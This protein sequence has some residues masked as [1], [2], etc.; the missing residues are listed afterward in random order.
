MNT[1]QYYH[2]L[3]KP[4]FAPPS[5]IFGIVWPFLYLL[6]A[7]SFGYVFYQVLVKKQWSKK[8]LVPFTLN[9]IS[10]ALY[11]PLF[12]TWRLLIPATIDILIVLSTIIWVIVLMNNKK[13]WVSFFQ[14]PY[15]IWVAFAAVL[16]VFVLFMNW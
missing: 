10:N 3:S 15:V 13:Q 11:S 12:F 2:S 9:I 1:E 6:M 5:G 8:L 14:V 4:F 7:I 16:Q